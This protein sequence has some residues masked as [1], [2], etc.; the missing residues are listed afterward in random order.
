MKDENHKSH[1]DETSILL[2]SYRK[3]KFIS[4][5]LFLADFSVKST[6]D[7]NPLNFEQSVNAQKS[8]LK[9]TNKKTHQ[10]L[11]QEFSTAP[12]TGTTAAKIYNKLP[13]S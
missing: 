9:K 4:S 12:S 5:P 7:Y 6:K 8:K 11:F 13:F 1:R 2:K 10:N 3:P